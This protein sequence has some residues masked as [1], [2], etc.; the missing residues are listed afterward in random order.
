MPVSEED[1]AFTALDDAADETTKP[2]AAVLNGTL[3]GIQANLLLHDLRH[4]PGGVY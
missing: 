1:L 4:D 2:I 3:S